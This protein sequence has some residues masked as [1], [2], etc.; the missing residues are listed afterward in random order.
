MSA[1]VVNVR[2]PVAIVTAWVDR[3]ISREAAVAGLVQHGD[4]TVHQAES[5]L[6]FVE[7]FYAQRDV[8]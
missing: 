8:A 7:R 6:S 5:L 4:R 1:V 3:E 2:D